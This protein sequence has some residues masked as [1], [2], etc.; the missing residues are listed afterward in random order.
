MYWGQGV[1]PQIRVDELGEWVRLNKVVQQ[2]LIEKQDELVDRLQGL[3]SDTL[4]EIV[5][6]H[7][8]DLGEKFLCRIEYHLLILRLL[9]ELS[10][11]SL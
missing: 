5:L 8:E 9:E 7:V 10:P 11:L 3:D 2:L 4:G 1:C 6:M